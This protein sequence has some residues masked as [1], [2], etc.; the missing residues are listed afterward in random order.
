MHVKGFSSK[1]IALTVDV[2]QSQKID[3]F[4]GYPGTFSL[5]IVQAAAVKGLR[6]AIYANKLSK[7][8]LVMAD[9]SMG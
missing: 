9:T 4:Q 7:R 5:E 1:G 2:I 6:I 8:H 3:C